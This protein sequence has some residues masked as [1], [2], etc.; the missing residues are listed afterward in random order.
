MSVNRLT[1][2]VNN[3]PGAG[4]VS[5]YSAARIRRSRLTAPKALDI[6]NFDT[7]FSEKNRSKT[8]KQW[9]KRPNDFKSS[10]EFPRPWIRPPTTTECVECKSTNRSAIDCDPDSRFQEKINYKILEVSKIQSEFNVWLHLLLQSF[11]RVYFA[12]KMFL[13]VWAPITL[14]DSDTR[15][16]HL[17]FIWLNLLLLL[18]SLSRGQRSARFCSYRVTASQL[19]RFYVLR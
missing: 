8:T 7:K 5:T 9:R 13:Y 14:F 10:T 17:S 11:R 19:W 1:R 3:Q 12:K 15:I 4:F 2:L 18:V 16:C 6:L